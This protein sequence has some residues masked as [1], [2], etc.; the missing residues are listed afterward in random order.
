M[1][2]K[3]NL[4][5]RSKSYSNHKSIRN[6]NFEKWFEQPRLKAMSKYRKCLPKLSLSIQRLCIWTPIIASMHRQN[7]ITLELFCCLFIV[8][9]FLRCETCRVLATNYQISIN[10]RGWAPKETDKHV[11]CSE[12]SNGFENDRLLSYGLPT[13]DGLKRNSSFSQWVLTYILKV[14]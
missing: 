14:D 9:T 10:S 4:Y 1:N 2:Q 12:S 7:P 3:Y 8:N 6:W 11:T 5:T 13:S